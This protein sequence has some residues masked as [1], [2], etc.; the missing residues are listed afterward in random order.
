MENLK[1]KK[2]IDIQKK[3]NNSLQEELDE[4]IKIVDKKLNDIKR[5]DLYAIEHYINFVPNEGYSGI[6]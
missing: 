1:K 6:M 4:I 3:I 5:D 2:N